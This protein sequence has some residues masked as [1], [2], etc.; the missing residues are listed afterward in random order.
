MKV[1]HYQWGNRVFTY[2][3]PTVNRKK[4]AGVILAALAG[5]AVLPLGLTALGLKKFLKLNPLFLVN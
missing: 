1:Q 4:Q 2:Y 5:E 3:K